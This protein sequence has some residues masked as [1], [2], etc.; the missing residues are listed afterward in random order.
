[1][2]RFLMVTGSWAQGTMTESL[3]I[4]NRLIKEAIINCSVMYHCIMGS[5]EYQVVRIRSIHL[6]IINHHQ[7]TKRQS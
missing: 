4:D 2:N 6:S 5:M 7:N 3:T 1:M